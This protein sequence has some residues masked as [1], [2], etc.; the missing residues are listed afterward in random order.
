MLMELIKDLI[1]VNKQTFVKTLNSIKSHWEALL[2]VLVY[3]LISQ[4]VFMLVRNMFV[5]ALSIVSGILIALIE[6]ALIS[7]FLFVLNN[8]VLYNRFRWKDV[9]E[10]LNY[11]LLKVYGILFIFFIVNFILSSTL[12]LIGSIGYLLSLIFQLFIIF[13]LNPLPETIYLKNYDSR[14][15]I[16]YCIEFIK[17]DFLNWFVPNIVLGVCLFFIVNISNTN[18]LAISVSNFIPFILELL[19]ISV[20]LS[21]FMIYRG[22]LFKLLSTSNRRKRQFMNKF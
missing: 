8:I 13:A 9:I 12:N 19:L 16:L 7:S 11:Y 17:G 1:D 14:G 3:V 5:G 2:I 15:S 20:F 6:A 21:F 22:H 10:G 4:T 18:L